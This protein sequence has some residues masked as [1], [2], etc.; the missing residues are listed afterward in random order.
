MEVGGTLQ[1]SVMSYQLMD[2]H[3]TK[4]NE[5][6]HGLMNEGKFDCTITVFRDYFC[7]L[8]SVNPPGCHRW[9]KSLGHTH[10]C[11]LKLSLCRPHFFK[12]NQNKFQFLTNLRWPIGAILFCASA[13]SIFSF[14]FHFPLFIHYHFSK[15]ASII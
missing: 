14:L 2:S 11:I 3:C 7:S 15:K 9:A 13:T 4:Q 12:L 5:C 10:A 8:S 6:M 1:D